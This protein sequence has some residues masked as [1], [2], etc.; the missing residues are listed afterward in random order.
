MVQQQAI[1]FYFKVIIDCLLQE[2]IIT[3]EISKLLL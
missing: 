3:I 1:V 2:A